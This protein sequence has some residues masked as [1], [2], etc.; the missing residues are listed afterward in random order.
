MRRRLFTLLSALSLLL[1]L[2]TLTLTIASYYVHERQFPLARQ[3]LLLL[4]HGR[5]E[6]YDTGGMLFLIPYGLFP[7]LLAILPTLWALDKYWPP[8]KPANS[9]PTCSY[10]LTGNT[11]GT[12]P[13]CGTPI[14]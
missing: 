12:C 10:N 8:K 1:F 7:L 11:S 3:R 9:C 13:E 5:A 2:T 6:M 4:A 14:T